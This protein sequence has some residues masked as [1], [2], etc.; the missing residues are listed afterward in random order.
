MVMAGENPQLDA[1]VLRIFGTELVDLAVEVRGIEGPSEATLPSR[2]AAASLA[3]GD[4]PTTLGVLWVEA[5]EAGNLLLHLVDPS[6][7]R[8]LV[9][10]VS[11]TPERPETA[12]ESLAVIARG[13]TQALLEGRAIGMEA[14]TKEEPV[15]PE[16][17]P[18]VVT[19]PPPRVEDTKPSRTRGPGRLRLD[20]AYVGTIWTPDDAIQWQSG[21]Q[22]G[23]GWRFAP[24]VHA[25]LGYLVFPAAT[26]IE[27][28]VLDEDLRADVTIARHPV[29]A[30]TGYPYGFHLGAARFGR[31]TVQGELGV[32]LDITRRGDDVFYGLLD[33]DPQLEPD[34]GERYEVLVGLPITV[35]LAYCPLPQLSIYLAG[36]AEPILRNASYVV[37][38]RDANGEVFASATATTIP[39]LLPLVNAGLLRYL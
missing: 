24:G 20:V 16:K 13:I 35:G 38:V 29:R 37:N 28:V 31:I 30:T 9:R 21:V 8:M 26:R 19:P 33:V 7:E 12:I 39:R 36:G 15:R 2:I 27:D 25:S 10:R 23:L 6:G 34:G 14:V 3:A 11:A 5:D 32:E 17:P 4:E 1:D 18:V 22:L